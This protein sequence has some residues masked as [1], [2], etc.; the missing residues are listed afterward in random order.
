MASESKGMVFLTG[1]GS[2]TG[3]AGGGF[4]SEPVITPIPEPAEAVRFNPED[5]KGEC[6]VL[7][8]K[9]ANIYLQ[10][11]WRLVATVNGKY[12][13]NRD[14]DSVVADAREQVLEAEKRAEEWEEKWRQAEDERACAVE[15]SIRLRSENEFA[16]AALAKLRGMYDRRTQTQYRLEEDLAKV[17]DAIGSLKWREIVGR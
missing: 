6:R 13:V 9:E 14:N 16:G 12:I 8:E 5:T 2:L 7:A 15:E 11:G 3:A 17:Q 1:T 4:H 10:R